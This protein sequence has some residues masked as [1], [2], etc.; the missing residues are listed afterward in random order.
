MLI[1]VRAKMY[2]RALSPA[3]VR[4]VKKT[5]LNLNWQ[6]RTNPSEL[7]DHDQTVRTLSR[8]P[9][10]EATRR[11]VTILNDML[12]HRMLPP[13]LPPQEFGQVVLEI[14]RYL[15]IH[16]RVER[17]TLAPFTMQ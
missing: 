14:R 2:S 5:V 9:K 4:C 6:V 8:F 16:S 13:S 17:G 3:G 10:I 15:Y 1:T 12:V 7:D 11:V